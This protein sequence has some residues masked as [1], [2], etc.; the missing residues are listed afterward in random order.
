MPR[1]LFRKAAA[2]SATRSIMS[3][4]SADGRELVSAQCL[5]GE[6]H[7]ILTRPP[8][9]RRNRRVPGPY[10]EPLSDA[11]TPLADFVNSL[12]ERRRPE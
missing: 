10:V 6:A 12:L 4:T 5:K 7:T 3:V 9:A 8:T 11:I 1:R 2:R